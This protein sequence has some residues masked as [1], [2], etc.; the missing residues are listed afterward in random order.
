[1]WRKNRRPAQCKQSFF[2]TVCCEGVDLNRNFDWFWA[3]TG[4]SSDPCHETYHGPSA[5]SEP[6]SAAVRDFVT[7]L[8][9]RVKG[10]VTLHS[11]SQMWI[12]PYGHRRRAYP[13]D[14]RSA[15]R[16][17]AVRAINALK[18]LHGTQYTVGTGADIMYE[19]AGGSADWAKGRARI[20]YSYLLELRPRNINFANGFLL[21][22]N[23]ILPTAEETWEAIKV[24]ADELVGQFGQPIIERKIGG[25]I[26]T[27]VPN[28]YRL[29]PT[30]NPDENSTSSSSSSSSTTT[31]PTTSPPTSVEETTATELL[32]TFTP[33][34]SESTTFQSTTFESTT[35]GSTTIEQTTTASITIEPATNEPTISEHCVDYSKFCHW[36][37]TFGLC[38]RER[39]SLL[40]PKSCDLNCQQR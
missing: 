25:G 36:W 29:R 14:Y 17:L 31:T 19:A 10:F 20:P 30:L 2:R 28:H 27:L 5:F 21:P 34:T 18:V 4:S 40:C 26:H 33:T 37:R 22:E 13:Q 3:S 23:Q 8:G 16:P 7:S 9:E 24:V 32:T 15:L 6:E 1:M 38:D 11:Y 35:T 12:I 39:V